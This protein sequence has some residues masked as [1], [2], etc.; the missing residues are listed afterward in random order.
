[1]QV[2][3]QPKEVE[4]SGSYGEQDF[5]I[6]ATAKSFEILSSSLY[7]DKILAIVRELACNAYDSHVAANK[8]DVPVE[9]RLPSTLDPVFHVRDFGLGLSDFAVRGGWRNPDTDE[10]LSPED[11]VKMWTPPEGSELSIHELAAADG[12]FRVSGIYTTFFESTKTDSNDYVGQLGLGSK[13]PFSYATAFMVEAIHDGVKRLYS[14]FKNEHN[15]PAITR[16]GEEATDECNGLTVTVP[17]R[18]GD[19]EKFATAARRALM[20]FKP[21]PSIVGRTDVEPYQLSHTVAGPNWCIRTTGWQANIKGPYVVQGFVSYP[22]DVARLKEVGLSTTAAALATANADFYVPI[23][24]VEVA[25]SREALSYDARTIRNL[26]DTIE[27]AAAEVRNTF[28]LQFDKCVCLWEVASLYRKLGSGTE[29]G[30]AFA[31]MFTAMHKQ[32]PFVWKDHPVTQHVAVLFDGVEHTNLVYAVRSAGRRNQLNTKASWHPGWAAKGITFD[33]SHHTQVIVDDLARSSRATIAEHLAKRSGTTAALII[34]PSKRK[35]FVQEEVDTILAAIGTTEYVLASSFAPATP[36]NGTARATRSK[37][38]PGTIRRFEGTNNRSSKWSPRNWMYVD[39]D[40]SKGGIYVPITGS[41]P[42]DGYLCC[43]TRTMENVIVHADHLGIVKRGTAIYGMTEK[44]LKIAQKANPTEWVSLR[45]LIVEE[46]SDLAEVGDIQRARV[47]RVAYDR[48]AQP[49]RSLLIDNWAQV[50]DSVHDGQFKQ[51]VD[52]AEVAGR[53]AKSVGGQICLS[54][55]ALRDAFHVKEGTPPVTEI[56]SFS[57]L[58]EKYPMMKYVTFE[59]RTSKWV[60]D[61]ITY[62]NAIDSVGVKP[63]S[64]DNTITDQQP[65]EATQV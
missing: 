56:E 62:V 37:P 32:Q 64:S 52:S 17:V 45:D 58:H 57:K 19:A 53:V 24:D 26:I 60:T 46:V 7:S 63:L 8:A 30:D 55:A 25:A 36:H 65:E 47:A 33:L 51:W 50:R 61:V 16:M 6:K 1:M 11:G 41:T 14:C 13:S 28:Q 23:G 5:T 48:I 34:T 40:L 49:I 35:N 21:V 2:H 38:A 31:T 43:G 59:T 12:F 20:Y 3:Y 29:S 15:M 18:T 44:E 4:R 10:K 54:Y 9:V 27:A 42:K 22:I 39:V